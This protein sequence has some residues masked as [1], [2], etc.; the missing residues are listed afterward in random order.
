M[1]SKYA[2]RL[3]KSL[4]RACVLHINQSTHKNTSTHKHLVACEKSR[5]DSVILTYLIA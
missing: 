2:H 4:Y 3:T 1:T 5:S